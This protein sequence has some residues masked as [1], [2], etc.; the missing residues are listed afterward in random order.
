MAK[1]TLKRICSNCNREYIVLLRIFSYDVY[2]NNHD[3]CPLCGER[4]DVWITLQVEEDKSDMFDELRQHCCDL[5]GKAEF[6][7]EA[8]SFVIPVD[9]LDDF[10]KVVRRLQ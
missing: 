10:E 8:N 4:D 3:N 6:D 7:E 5:M 9:I 1:Y 2:G